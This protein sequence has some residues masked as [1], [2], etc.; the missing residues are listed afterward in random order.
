MRPSWSKKRVFVRELAGTYSDDD[1]GWLDVLAVID[2]RDFKTSIVR[3]RTSIG[4]R[5]NVAVSYLWKAFGANNF[6]GGNAI[7]GGGLPLAGA[8]RRDG[9]TAPRPR[10]R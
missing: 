1:A 3:S 9:A 2:D 4:E 6:Y 10:A 5:S 7:V 8:V